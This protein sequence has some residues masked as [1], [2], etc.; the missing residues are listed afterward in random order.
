M[1]P[2]RAFW[3]ANAGSMGV[4][5]DQ[6]MH[7][8]ARKLCELVRRSWHGPVAGVDPVRRRSRGSCGVC[9][10]DFVFR[11]ADKDYRDAGIHGVGG[12]DLCACSAR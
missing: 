5:P 9:R 3:L 1:L 11:I 12:D 8:D 4:N 10:S 2:R 7:E 6:R